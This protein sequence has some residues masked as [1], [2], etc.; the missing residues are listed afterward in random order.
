MSEPLTELLRL[1]TSGDLQA[2]ERLYDLVEDELLSLA[3]DERHRWRGNVTLDTVAL[4]SNAFI[5]VRSS[6]IAWDSRRHFFAVTRKAMR[7]SLFTY[8]E[9]QSRQRRG[10]GVADVELEEAFTMSATEADAVLELRDALQ[11]LAAVDSHSAEIVELRYFAGLRNAEIGEL[12]DMGE[13]T[14]G[15]KLRTARGFLRKAIGPSGDVL[16]GSVEP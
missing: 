4:L 12:L 5:R 8:A 7:Q 1:A 11:E 13:S 6:S 16:W 15:R 2:E 9:A 14:V 10:G 3:R